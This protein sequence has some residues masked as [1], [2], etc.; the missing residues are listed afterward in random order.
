[1]ETH[2]KERMFRGKVPTTPMESLKDLC[3]MMGMSPLQFVGG[4]RGKETKKQ[5]PQGP[6]AL[7]ENSPVSL[8]FR[9]R[10]VKGTETPFTV[11]M[12][13]R[14]LQ[15]TITSTF[16]AKLRNQW[17]RS[18]TMTPLELLVTLRAGLMVERESIRFDYIKM[19]V[20]CMAVLRDLHSAVDATFTR[21]FGPEY[22]E[23]ETQ[24]AWV[25]GWVFLMASGSDLLRQKMKIRDTEWESKIM[26]VSGGVLLPWIAR[27]GDAEC[28]KLRKVLGAS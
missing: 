12:V 14:V 13:E 18:Q 28:V 19:H 20:R 27:E 24:L 17:A 25:V 9:E 6:S 15:E 21:A 26:G 11:A 22:F 2:G 23:N 10:I 7:E 5:S 4:N 3:Y 8:V 16:P 1:M